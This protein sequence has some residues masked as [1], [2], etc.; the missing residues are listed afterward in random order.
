MLFRDSCLRPLDHR[1]CYVEL[2]PKAGCKH[3]CNSTNNPTVGFEPEDNILFVPLK[4]VTSTSAAKMHVKTHIRH[5]QSS[6]SN[7]TVGLLVE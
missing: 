6:G 5:A 1:A 4:E 7:P 2:N 3:M